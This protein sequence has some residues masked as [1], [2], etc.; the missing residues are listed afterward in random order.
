MPEYYFTKDE[1]YH[2]GIK[3]QKWGIRRFQNEDGSL[4]AEGKKHYG[5]LSEKGAGATED[6]RNRK[7]YRSAARV[8]SFL[9]RGLTGGPGVGTALG[10][11]IR[12]TSARNNAKRGVAKDVARDV[13]E[14]GARASWKIEKRARNQ[15]ISKEQSRKVARKK[16][17]ARLTAMSTVGMA[18]SEAMKSYILSGGD[19]SETLLAARKGA[20]KGATVGSLGAAV[21]VGSN[22]LG[23]NLATNLAYR[24]RKKR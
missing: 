19:V 15:G 17:F 9:G 10:T 14:F 5:Y 20:L 23:A 11:A 13:N 3:G 8:G 18:A 16:Q 1:L 6:R 2:H 12:Y 22:Y 4:T 21:M 24:D 7:D